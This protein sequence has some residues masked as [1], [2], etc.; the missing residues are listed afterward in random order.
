MAWVWIVD[1]TVVQCSFADDCKTIF[2]FERKKSD[3]LTKW[4]CA[5]VSRLEV[6]AM[7]SIYCC[8]T[9]FIHKKLQ[10][11]WENMLY[12]PNIFFFT[13]EWYTHIFVERTRACDTENNGDS[14]WYWRTLITW[15]SVTLLT[16][17][18][19]YFYNSRKHFF[20]GF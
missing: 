10:N 19:I 3:S 4:C 12:L 11:E 7:Y 16:R 20:F 8:S 6:C 2:S 18:S 15:Q 14:F 1:K 9:R 5:W 13:F 17:N